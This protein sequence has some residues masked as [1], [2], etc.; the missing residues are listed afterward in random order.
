MGIM[1]GHVVIA[2][3]LF[4]TSGVMYVWRQAAEDWAWGLLALIMTSP[5]ETRCRGHVLAWPQDA[6]HCSS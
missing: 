2:D 6:L 4:L 1:E 3:S 5:A